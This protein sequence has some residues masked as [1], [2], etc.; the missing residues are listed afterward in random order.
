VELESTIRGLLRSLSELVFDF[1]VLQI[2]QYRAGQ[3]LG[4]IA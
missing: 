1:G 2:L 4:C 3:R